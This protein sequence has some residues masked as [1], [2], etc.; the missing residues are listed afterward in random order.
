MMG[1]GRGAL[2]LSGAISKTVNMPEDVTVEDVEQLHIDAWEVGDQGQWPSTATTARSPSRS[3][4]P[5]WPA[6]G[7]RCCR[8]DGWR[9]RSSG[10][11][12]N[13]VHTG[14]QKGSECG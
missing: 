12:S 4:P 11:D 7:D 2:H 8:D 6:R 5:K 13:D 14:R 9:H 1:D 10:V 3:Q